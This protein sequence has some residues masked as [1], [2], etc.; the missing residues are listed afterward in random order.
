MT[1]LQIDF[2]GE[3]HRVVP[4]SD[5]S[6]GRD[7]DLVIDTNRHLHRR[8]GLFRFSEA[9]WCLHNTGS[10]I[11]LEVCD[12]L[13]FSRLTIAPGASAPI[14]FA[15]SQVRFQAGRSRYEFDI[16]V[17]L[18]L[19]T[20][21]LTDLTDR[22]APTVTAS[23]V[24]LNDEQR[25]LLTALAEPLLAAGR[26]GLT[27]LPTNRGVA[28]QLGW[29]ITKFNRKLDALCTKFTKLGVP[30]LKGDQGS[31]A[32]SRRERLI[33]HVVT[34]GIITKRDLGLLDDDDTDGQDG[35]DGTDELE[36][37]S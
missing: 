21:G 12:K 17:D 16:D 31:L 27:D 5:F 4:G 35:T 23:N 36:D 19:A 22:G 8:L 7:A 32:S 34:V 18:A 2:I 28:D 10:A 11:V 13:S 33:D 29:T 25:L 15:S 37:D 20:A 6:F 3:V 14:A 24:P 9:G 1:V 26:V 30:G